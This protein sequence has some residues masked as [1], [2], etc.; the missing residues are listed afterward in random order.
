[1]IV[2]QLTDVLA[3]SVCSHDEYDR[4]RQNGKKGG[5]VE[6]RPAAHRGRQMLTFAGALEVAFTTALIRVGFTPSEAKGEA[7]RWLAD[8]KAG[9]LTR[10]W[11]SNPMAV[12]RRR[13]AKRH[14]S[15]VSLGRGLN[16]TETFEAMCMVMPNVPEAGWV[17]DDA[18]ARLVSA[19]AI[20]CI[21]RGSIVLRMTSLFD[22]YARSIGKRAA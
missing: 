5:F 6:E 14:P 19:S 21:D 12:M 13:A 7:R 4:W 11:V 18:A 22:T 17:G 15:T 20:V 2:A 3:V 1:M 8:Q 9:K 10:W 16:N